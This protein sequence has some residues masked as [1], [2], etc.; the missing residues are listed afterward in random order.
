[1]QDKCAEMKWGIYVAII[2]KILQL[3]EFIR[4][5]DGGYCDFS[6]EL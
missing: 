1:M 3:H 6:P 2:Y 5:T 4:M